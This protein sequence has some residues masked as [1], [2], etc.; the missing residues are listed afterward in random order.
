MR[1]AQPLQ[2][3][4]RKLQIVCSFRLTVRDGVE[5]ADI[6]YAADEEASAGSGS[7]ENRQRAAMEDEIVVT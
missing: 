2:T 4:R 5:D 1:V 3:V 6:V 7:A